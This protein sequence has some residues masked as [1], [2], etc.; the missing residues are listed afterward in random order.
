[1]SRYY[2]IIYRILSEPVTPNEIAMKLG[3][4][5]KTEGFDAFNTHEG[6]CEVHKLW[7]NTYFLKIEGM[8]SVYN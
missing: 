8:S 5:Q 3:V 7:E 2:E 6:K 1:M 4:T